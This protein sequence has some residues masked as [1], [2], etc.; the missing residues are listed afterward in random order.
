MK[1]NPQ[2]E[3]I[4]SDLLS[5]LAHPTKNIFCFLGLSGT[6]K[7]FTLRKFFDEA[8]AVLK[9]YE[10][11][12]LDP[13]SNIYLTAPTHKAVEVLKG[14]VPSH[15]KVTTIY[16]LFRLIPKYNKR[17]YKYD[18]VQTGAPDLYANSV[19]MIDESSML[20]KEVNLIIDT[21]KEQNIKLIFIGDPDQ[22]VKDDSKGFLD[23]AMTQYD[24]GFLTQLMRNDSSIA[25]LAHKYRKSIH[26]RKF[27]AEIKLDDSIIYLDQDEFIAQAAH[28]FNTHVNAKVL[29]FKRDTADKYNHLIHEELGNIEP[30]TKGQLV[31]F[32]DPYLNK[33]EE[34]LVG[35]NEVTRIANV[36]E[37]KV[38]GVDSYHLTVLSRKGH[39]RVAVPK[40][41]SQV[42][43]L[44]KEYKK[45]ND[46][47]QFCLLKRTF[48]DVSHTYAT[49]TDKSQGS[50]YDHVYIDLT[51]LGT[52]FK[53][54]MFSRRMYVGISRA[55]TKVIFTGTLPNHYIG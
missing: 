5:F 2:Q 46:W 48:A 55:T 6:G 25:V 16:S 30:F 19:I 49:T 17:T 28:D 50:T 22:I 11:M 41:K 29:T 43:T 47:Q 21:C 26:N 3:Q 44:M 14:I 10:S 38:E 36:T 31:T 33:Q 15:V 40:K 32:N 27:P 1:L 39:V 8:P 51:D 35:N 42:K 53:W 20:G 18:L 45:D 13:A 54:D 4:L 12:G 23:K 52:C 34:I 9:V 37:E 24:S 7:S